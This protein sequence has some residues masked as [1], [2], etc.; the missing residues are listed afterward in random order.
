MGTIKKQIQQNPRNLQVQDAQQP[1][2]RNLQQAQNAQQSQV[3]GFQSPQI[4]DYQRPCDLQH[5]QTQNTQCPQPQ[6]FQHSQ[7][8]PF[9]VLDRYSDQ[10]RLHRELEEKMERL[11]ERY[12]L[13]CFF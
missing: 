3:Q 10:I 9:D 11:N 13:D 1:Q 7:S 6:N 8:Q 2:Q 5:F 12:G 4:Q